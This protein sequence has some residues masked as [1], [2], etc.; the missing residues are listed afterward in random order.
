M[1]LSPHCMLNV[2]GWKQ[3]T[4]DGVERSLGGG[5]VIFTDSSAEHT[6]SQ[7]KTGLLFLL[8]DIKSLK[9]NLVLKY[10]DHI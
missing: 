1:S 10:F 3:Q 7:P 6:K 5:G 4:G 2:G 9:Q 8:F